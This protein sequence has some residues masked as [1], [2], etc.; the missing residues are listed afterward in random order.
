MKINEITVGN[1]RVYGNTCVGCVAHK[2][3]V[4]LT[5]ASSDKDLYDCFMS[6]QQAL[7][8]VRNTLETLR[9]NTG[10]DIPFLLQPTTKLDG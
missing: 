10:I 3:D 8:L 4:M 2:A 9:R 5:V 7:E 1:V 6:N